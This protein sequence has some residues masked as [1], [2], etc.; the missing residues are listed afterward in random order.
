MIKRKYSDTFVPIIY[1]HDYDDYAAAFLSHYGYNEWIDTP[2]AVPICEIAQKKMELNICLARLSKSGDEISGLIALADGIVDVYDDT[3]E[4]YIGI[5]AKKGDVLLEASCI[6]PGRQNNSLAHECVHWWLHR[7]YFTNRSGGGDAIAFRCPTT[8]MNN[9]SE[10]PTDQEWMERQARG[11]CGRILMPKAATIKRTEELLAEQGLAVEFAKEEHYLA[12]AESLA[13]T[14]R[15]SREAALVRLS[16]L[17]K[18][19]YN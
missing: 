7:L 9:L 4:Q 11:I 6:N 16:Q 18:I 1:A 2:K 19:H 14:F 8:Q 13:S 10:N 5:S 17:E 12:M 3:T 15:V